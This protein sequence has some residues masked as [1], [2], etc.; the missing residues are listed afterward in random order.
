MRARIPDTLQRMRPARGRRGVQSPG[1]GEARPEPAAE[2]LTPEV[3]VRNAGGPEDH[4]HYTCSCG[5]MF[6]ASVST[7]VACPHCGGEQAW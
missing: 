6:T 7:S 1:H 2:P 3:R 4:A 5:F